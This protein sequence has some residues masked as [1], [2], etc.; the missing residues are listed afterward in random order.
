MQFFDSHC[1]VNSKEFEQDADEVFR[2]SLDAG[3]GMNILG[4]DL[5]SSKR[6]VELAQKYDGV[7]ASVGLYPSNVEKENLEY[8]SYK[9]LAQHDEVVAIGEIGLDY[10]RL[11]ENTKSQK[12]QKHEIKEKQRT[13]F[14]EQIKS[15]RELDLPVVIHTRATSGT[16]DV[17][18]DLLEILSSPSQRE[19]SGGVSSGGSPLFGSPLGKGRIRG[20][21]HSYGGTLEY[22]QKFL[23]LG[24][25]LG[26][27]GII[28]FKKAE[29]VRE[30][31]KQL[32]LD[33]ILIETDAPY[34]APVEEIVNQ[35]T[36]NSIKLFDLK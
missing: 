8:E 13:V 9:D 16:Q 26:F 15:A 4:T 2:R 31:V 11:T 20:V 22:A 30:V 10:Y 21:L 25:Y 7:Y 3:I 32:P 1:H 34:L 12:T 5:E 29:E 6:A 28:T 23:D 18:E 14:L 35:T 33:K 27:N 17:F 19:I 36:E 24:F